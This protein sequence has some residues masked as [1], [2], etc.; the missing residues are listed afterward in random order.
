MA[1][2]HASAGEVIDVQPLGS[3]IPDTKTRTLL[4]TDDLE[5]LRLVLPAGKQIAEHK[6]RGEITV[7]CLEG[8]VK[9]TIGGQ[10]RDLRAGTMLFLHAG[11]PHAVEAV[12]NSSI[13]VTLLL[14]K[15]G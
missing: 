13:L 5:V 14:N 10:V 3:K 15:K 8:Q 7:H 2:S 6:A 1:I 9:F 12:E 4:K 11:E